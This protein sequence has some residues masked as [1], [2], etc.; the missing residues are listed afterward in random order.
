MLRAL[1][2]LSLL[3]IVAPSVAPAVHA[4]AP[5]PSELAVEGFPGAVPD[6]VVA[7]GGLRSWAELTR[8]WER[9]SD[10]EPS[11]YLPSWAVARLE[12]ELGPIDKW[13][14]QAGPVRAA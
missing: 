3:S 2:L 10:V 6:E 11:F 12:R 8:A 5:K 7:I 13:L 9:A 4:A 1:V 14:D